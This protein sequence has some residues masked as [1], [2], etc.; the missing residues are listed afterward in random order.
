MENLKIKCRTTKNQNTGNSS[1]ANAL[2]SL[3]GSLTSKSND[4]SNFISSAYP[5]Q[6]KYK[7]TESTATEAT[8]NRESHY[9]TNGHHIHHSKDTKET[10]KTGIV[11]PHHKSL[12]IDP[13]DHSTNLETNNSN[14]NHGSG[15][16]THKNNI[17]NT[18]KNTTSTQKQNYIERI[19]NGNGNGSYSNNNH[20]H[21]HNPISHTPKVGGN[22][23][24]QVL[25]KDE[26]D[27]IGRSL[28]ESFKDNFLAKEQQTGRISYNKN[29]PH[30][31]IGSNA[32]NTNNN[33]ENHNNDHKDT[34]NKDDDN[35]NH[36]TKNLK[37]YITTNN[38]L[39]NNKKDRDGDGTNGSRNQGPANSNTKQVKDF[40]KNNQDNHQENNQNQKE[41]ISGTNSNNNTGSLLNNN[42]VKLLNQANVTSPRKERFCQYYM[43]EVRNGFLSNDSN[44][45]TN[46]YRD[47]F[48]QSYQAYSVFRFAP[49]PDLAEVQKRLVTLPDSKGMKTLIFDLD[50]TLIHCTDAQKTKGEISLPITFPTGETIT[51][52]INIRPYAKYALE[53]LSKY[54]QIVVFTASHSCYAN[55]VIDYLD[56]DNKYVHR[57]LFRENCIF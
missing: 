37:D 49:M 54:F 18:T 34:N 8:N 48:F 4:L 39:D 10:N 22:K 9:N 38:D 20:S 29:L 3:S 56:P 50:E 21:Q 1:I 14:L 6:V 55:K 28:R 40:L 5:G 53:E 42:V 12:K 46:L 19:L 44:Y 43:A 33:N 51:A 16:S 15:S 27:Y 30:N 45:F 25:K 24:D 13:G 47:H 7:M 31:N 35:Q 41:N 36:K 57:R 52:G 17:A 2:A 32:K 23:A 11:K 26:K